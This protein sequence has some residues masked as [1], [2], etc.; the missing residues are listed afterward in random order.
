M[1]FPSKWT[2]GAAT[3]TRVVESE[4]PMQGT[5]LFEDGSPENF[6]KHSWLRPHFLTES[7]R[8]IG[9]IQAFLVESR[10]ERILVDTCVG[11]DKRRA[12]KHWHLRKGRFLEDLAGVG[13][14]RQTVSIV[15]CTHMHVDHVG[16]NTILVDD[17][18]IPTFPN[19][20]YLFARREWEH[21]SAEAM[22]PDNDPITDSIRPVV[23]AGLADFVE[24]DYQL[25]E[26]VS[27]EPT[28]GHTPGHVS[29]RIR[30]EGCEAAITGDLMHHPVQLAEPEWS[31]KADSN[32]DV[33][34][35]TRR[36][37]FKRCADRPIMVFGTHFPT[38][39]AGRI[40]TDGNAWRFDIRADPCDITRREGGA[41]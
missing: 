10:G 8:P 3:I 17:A 12:R 28:P 33:A 39:P 11:N 34:R 15:L 4:G 16:W 7:G 32:P 37:F 9:S 18:W 30:S 38:P 22:N 36:A 5:F 1:F 25:T 31:N 2:L 35:C 41:S 20:R 13:Y 14:P 6:L 19:A 29:V 26:E 27:L 40:V 24:S 23:E 21:W